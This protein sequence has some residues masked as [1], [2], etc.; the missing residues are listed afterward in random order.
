MSSDPDYKNWTRESLV[1]RVELLENQLKFNGLEIPNDHRPPP[2]EGQA[3][4]PEP[5]KR[6]YYKRPRKQNAFDASK[7]STRLI[8]LKLAYLGKNYNGFEHQISASV[9]TIEEELWK[10]LVKSCLISPPDGPDKVDFNYPALQY[11]KCGRTDRGV[12]AFGQVIGIRVRSNRPMR[13][14]PKVCEQKEE[15]TGEEVTPKVEVEDGV[16]TQGKNK[17]QKINQ[18]KPEWDPIADEMNYPRILNRLLPPE[19]RILAW[20]PNP[21][22]GFDARFSCRERQYRYFFTQPAFIPIPDGISALKKPA[23]VKEGW[24]DIDAMRT[25]AKLFEGTHD[26]RNFCKVDPAKQIGNYVR[27]MFECDIV[28]VDDVGS[29]IPYLSTP[30][31]RPDSFPPGTYP[32]VYYFHVR[33]SAFLWHQIRHMVAVLFLV[34]Q[35]LETPSIVSDLLDTDKTPGRPNYHLAD[36]VPLVLW[37]CIF[38]GAAY[39]LH[40][41]TPDMRDRMAWIWVGEDTPANLH[42]HSGLAPQMWE[43]WRERKVDEVLANRFLDM[44]CAQADMVR[45][46]E[47]GATALA[48]RQ[49][50]SPKVFLGG[51]GGRDMGRYLPV[52]EK[53]VLPSPEEMNDAWAR[54]NGFGSSEE[55]TRRKNWRTALKAAK[56]KAVGEEKVDGDGQS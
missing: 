23:A 32:K 10:A 31:V 24:L 56:R 26:F 21:E 14:D 39:G 1:K 45:R 20:C 6:K 13:Q 30:D 4:T 36:E 44:V 42:G 9:P 25:A 35:G 12:S 53:P 2:I 34:G 5:S 29:A 27:R 19:I 18:E 51:N 47:R 43:L 7:Y 46:T 28:E 15:A 52:L 38:P 17:K 40:N 11:S 48:T 54:K 50:D 16:E 41:L 55:L 37:D 22:E 49:K 8:A 33:G 3:D